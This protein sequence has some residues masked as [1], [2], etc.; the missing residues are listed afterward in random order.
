MLCRLVA[1]GDLGPEARIGERD[2]VGEA[3][4]ESPAVGLG[5]AGADH[6]RHARRRAAPQEAQLDRAARRRLL[7]QPDELAHVAERLSVPLHQ[8]VVGQKPGLRDGDLSRRI[9]QVDSQPP[10]ANVAAGLDDP[11]GRGEELGHGEDECPDPAGRGRRGSVRS[12]VGDESEDPVVGVKQRRPVGL[13]APVDCD[14]P[15]TERAGL[16]RADAEDLG[17]LELRAPLLLRDRQ[18][19]G[20]PVADLT[21]DA[22]RGL[23]QLPFER[24]HDRDAGALVDADELAPELRP[25]RARD[26][27]HPQVAA[28]EVDPAVPEER[29]DVVLV[30][31]HDPERGEDLDDGRMV[32]GDRPAVQLHGL[33]CAPRVGEALEDGD[34][35]EPRVPGA[36]LLGPDARTCQ[37]DHTC[38][39]P[40]RAQHGPRVQ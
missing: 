6:G 8:D 7:N 17:A 19:H 39:Q 18:D 37:Q 21:A 20:R 34:A 1:R 15:P 29:D 2:H 28:V 30:V 40:R 22:Q 35:H 32:V 27:L 33:S 31:D 23:P 14:L 26:D 38:H 16:R 24:A 13:Q 9:V 11:A 25:F 4:D 10:G 36:A 3:H 12:L 5:L